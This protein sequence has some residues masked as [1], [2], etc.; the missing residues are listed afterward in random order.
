MDK[1]LSTPIL[2]LIFKRPDTTQRV[3]NE[4][5]KAK[6]E[7]LYVSAD[8]PRTDKKGEKEKCQQT[9][10]I[11]KQVDWDC[12]VYTN[13]S[14]KHLGCKYACS[15]GISWFFDNVEEGI[16]LEDD[17]LPAQSFFWFC[18]TLL[19]KYRHDERIAMISGNNFQNEINRSEGSYYFSRIPHIWGWATWR[20]TWKQY[21]V[22]MKTFPVFLKQNQIKNIYD[23]KS[24]QKCWL[25][26]FNTAYNGL[27]DS[28]D[29]PLVY[30]IQIQNRL[31]INP[32]VNL[33]ENIGFGEEG[34]HTKDKRAGIPRHEILEIT[35]PEFILV[36]KEAE[37]YVQ[38]KYFC[39]P[40]EKRILRILTNEGI[41]KFI[42]RKIK[43]H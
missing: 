6:P 25:K 32:T 23:D 22:D 3:F 37:N 15:S 7:K 43:R 42:Q 10:D 28:W 35:H 27:I 8:G 39:I 31:C 38:K 26:I 4:I 16:I 33:V 41:I 21:D 5:K 14:D 36:D 40:I 29:Y 34:T 13:F 24:T 12:E 20:R 11:I 19:E 1:T 2:F 30:S 18:Q 17:C 9:R